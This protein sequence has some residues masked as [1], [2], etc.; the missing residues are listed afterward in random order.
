MTKLSIKYVERII[1]KGR[2]YHYYKRNGK[3]HGSLLGEV[4]TL[5]FTTEYDRIHKT[6]G[7]LDAGVTFGTIS[8]LVHEYKQSADFLTLS[9]KSK[10]DYGHHLERIKFHMGEHHIKVVTRAAVMIYRDKLQHK[11]ATCN[12]RMAV[13]RRLMSF[14]VDRG[15][16]EVNPATKP[17]KLE[18][19]TW[20]PWTQAQIEAMRMT[21]KQGLRTAL[22]L[23]L[24]TGQRQADIMSMTWARDKKQRIEVRQEKTGNIVSIPIHRDLRSYLSTIEKNSST[25]MVVSSKGVPYKQN[26]F[27]HEWKDEMNRF[28]IQGVVFHGLRKNATNSL[29]EAGC[30]E[31]E[32][33]AITGM[34]AQMVRHYAKRVNQS[35]L[36]DSAMA[37]LEKSG[38]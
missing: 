27:K 20:E 31:H 38:E 13:L 35:K 5:E 19:G 23:A 36:A 28:G 18:I 4:G 6:F 33:S 14:A 21:A 8:A 37:K 26:H 9:E 1:S 11:P 22:Y 24:Y 30:T 32:V 17:K 7:R 12:Y 2:V 10:S 16:I 25:N 15:Y 29:L 3:R 34:S